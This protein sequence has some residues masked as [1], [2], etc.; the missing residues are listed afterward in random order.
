M[1]ERL[2]RGADTAPDRRRAGGGYLLAADDVGKTGKAGLAPPQR[3]HPRQREDRLQP[4]IQFYQR[5]DGVF[6]VRLGFEV[7]GHF[8]ILRHG[9]ALSR[10][11]TTSYDVCVVSIVVAN[12]TLCCKTL[13]AGTSP[14]MTRFG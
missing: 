14:A 8:F 4:R 11:S 7:D 10:P 6:E 9:R 1:I 3:R 2:E 5:M 13:M 12:V